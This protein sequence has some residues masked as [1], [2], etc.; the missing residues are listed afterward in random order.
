M[1]NLLVSILMISVGEGEEPLYEL[2]EIVITAKRE[3]SEI[4]SNTVCERFIEVVGSTNIVDAVNFLPGVSFSVGSRNEPILKIRGFDQRQVL[5]LLDGVPV[6]VPYDGQVDLSQLPINDIAKLKVIRS[7]SSILYGP[8]SMGGV[9]N[10][11]T[12]RGT[13]TPRTV[14]E[15]GYGRGKE[16]IIRLNHGR[17]LGKISIQLSMNYEKREGYYLSNNFKL[18]LNEDGGLRENSDFE[19]KCIGFKLTHYINKDSWGLAFNYVDNKKGVPPEVGSSR[20][21]YWRF[22]AWQKGTMRAFGEK[23]FNNE[24]SLK[25]NLFYDL[26]YNVLDSYDDS[27]YSTQTKRYAFHSTYDDYSAGGN[28]MSNILLNPNL[29]VRAGINFKKDVHRQQSDY[30]EPWERYEAALYS[31]GIEAEKSWKAFSSI[32]GLGMKSM[33]PLYAN[34]GELRPAITTFDPMLGLSYGMGLTIFHFSLGKNTRFPTLKELYSEHLGKYIKNPDLKEESSLN[35]DIG[36]KHYTLRGIE[37]GVSFFYSDVTDLIEKV[38]VEYDTTGKPV[39]YQLKNLNK[40]KIRGIE[41]YTRGELKFTGFY[42]SY[43]HTEPKI[44]DRYLEYRPLDKASMVLKF[45]LLKKIKLVV[46]GDYVG[47]RYYWENDEMEYLSPYTLVGIGTIWNLN[48]FI[49]VEFRIKN[50]FDTNH[51]YEKGFPGEGRDFSF[52]M[53]VKI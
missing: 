43:T 3:V 7:V 36:L 52:M 39:L 31:L 19:K 47:K 38:P 40:A 34:G 29:T 16:R 14:I 42:F 10:I 51:E 4:T 1:L 44:E 26:Y 20:P 23:A 46:N 30:G 27:T 32:I 9:I 11:I 5:V 49:G 8:N 18:A 21:R 45:T 22:T 53:R 28:L 6:Y 35:F 41:L 2:E 33:K 12:K 15:G 24:I 17:S 13:P 50:L 25:G 37:F 48:P